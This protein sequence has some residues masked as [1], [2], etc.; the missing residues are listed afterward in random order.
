MN[1][2]DPATPGLA[3]PELVRVLESAAR[4]Q[5]V[6]P[7][8]VLVGG[9]A[10]ALWANH[11][12]SSD[13]DHVLEDLSA[14]FDA[15]L[16]AIETTEGWVTNRITP[17]KI[18]LGELGDI[19]SGVRQLIRNRPLEVTEVTL[20][21]GHV[22]RVPTPDETLRIKGYLIVRRNQV[23]DYLDVAAL[24]D[25]YGIPHSA[26]VLG[27]IDSYYSDQRGSGALGVA[28]QLARQLADPRPADARTIQQL[29]RYKGLDTRWTNWKNVTDV[30]RSVAVEMVQ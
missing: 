22:L 19:E 3:R 2:V 17:G 20:P 5:E 12:S 25:R 27:H 18:I 11:R 4:L 26:D 9:S 23:R 13:H 14:R 10:A 16:D 8:A 6:V 30:C 21:S 24:S 29:D 7:D 1:A 15:V 28:T